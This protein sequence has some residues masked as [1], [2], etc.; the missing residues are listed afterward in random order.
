MIRMLNIIL[1]KVPYIHSYLAMKLKDLKLTFEVTFE[2]L[3][4]THY[5]LG[6]L[7]ELQFSI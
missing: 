4:N 5:F 1:L 7:F 6:Q 2:S 3:K